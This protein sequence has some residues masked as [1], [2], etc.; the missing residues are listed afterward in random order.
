M[1]K[2][3]AILL[4]T[5]ITLLSLS[6]T[7]AAYDESPADDV[8]SEIDSGYYVVL[9][10]DNWEIHEE[11]RMTHRFEDT[12]EVGD[13]SLT[14]EDRIKVVYSLDLKTADGWYPSEED[15]GFAPK[16]N[17]DYYRIEF[18]P[19]ANG[20]SDGDIECYQGYI[21]AIPCEPPA[22]SIQKG[23]A[24]GDGK[25]TVLDATCI[26]KDL[27]GIALPS[28]IV[29]EAAD[30]DGDGGVS[31]IDATCIQRFLV[32]LYP[33]TVVETNPTATL[34][35]EDVNNVY[36][37]PHAAVTVTGGTA[38]YTYCY[39]IKGAFHGGSNYGEDFGEYILD[40][41]DPEPG[42]MN[43]TT[44]YI[45]RSTTVIPVESLTYG[46]TFTLTVTV[47]DKNGKTSEPVSVTFVNAASQFS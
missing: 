37:H 26:Q 47:K 41:S 24:D 46:D 11:N 15:E 8:T 22:G 13:I 7:V 10:K 16:F 42:D 14:T 6:M 40:M 17:S 32:G 4:A 20:V 34:S 33:L 29:K 9:E 36:S 44:G 35:L 30:V 21:R 45:D 5:I 28:P 12:Y 2:V 25:V 18:Y 38:P 3:T 23:D 39:K 1:K 27:A 19:S 31:I 43:F